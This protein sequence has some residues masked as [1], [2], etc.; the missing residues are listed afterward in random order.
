[1]TVTEAELG[2]D[3]LGASWS[4]GHTTWPTR[5]LPPIA[6]PVD[7]PIVVPGCLTDP[8]TLT[9]FDDRASDMLPTLGRYFR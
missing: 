7:W 8:E 2:A 3:P 4:D 9:A 6:G 5:G 1:M